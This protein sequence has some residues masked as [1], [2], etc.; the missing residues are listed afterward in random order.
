[1][2]RMLLPVFGVT[3]SLLLVGPAAAQTGVLRGSFTLSAHAHS[4]QFGSPSGAPTLFPTVTVPSPGRLGTFAY[5]AIPCDQP[6]PFNDRALSFEPA[7][8]GVA[9]P[10]AVRHLIEGTITPR[11]A[12]GDSGV[13]S[14]TVTTILCEN[15]AE[16]DRITFSFHG[17]FVETSDNDLSIVGGRFVIAGGSGRFVDLVGRGTLEGRFT[18]LPAILSRNSAQSCAQLGA[19]SDAVFSLEGSFIDPSARRS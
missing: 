6:A 8:P 7:Y 19:F 14:G 2:K 15:G 12:S 1:M 17:R 18:C 13:V 3:A 10:A 5:S 16:G 4:R 9:S 11:T